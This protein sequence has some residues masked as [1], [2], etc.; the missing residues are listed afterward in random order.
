MLRNV[1][2]NAGH[3]IGVRL[4]GTRSNR[5]GLGAALEVTTDG[6]PTQMATVNTTGS[7]LSANDRTAHFGLGAASR[8][9]SVRVRWPSGAVQVVAS[10]P[11]DRVLTI[12]EAP[13]SPRNRA[14]LACCRPELTARTARPR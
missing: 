2:K 12:T 4:I 8:V 14:S 6:G 13:K 9:T 11:I 3:W 1:T 7:Y 5:D 10:P